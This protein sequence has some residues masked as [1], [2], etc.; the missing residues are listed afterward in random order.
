MEISK[1]KHILLICVIKRNGMCMKEWF[2]QW[3]LTSVSTGNN[4]KIYSLI[5]NI[6]EIDKSYCSI[7]I[8]S[9]SVR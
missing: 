2:Y 1:Y 6:F 8:P 4:S 5:E 3:Y 9:T 7:A